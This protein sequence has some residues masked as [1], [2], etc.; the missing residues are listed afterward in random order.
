MG[1][2]LTMQIIN[3]NLFNKINRKYHLHMSYKKQSFNISLNAYLI[4]EYC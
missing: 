2:K 3:G 1:R 4:E